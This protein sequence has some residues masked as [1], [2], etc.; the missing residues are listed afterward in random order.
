MRN[1]DYSIAT[2]FLANLFKFTEHAVEIR[3]LP[4]DTGGGQARPLFGRSLDLIEAH[5]QR[6]DDFGRAVYFGVCTR[7][8]GSPS[9]KRVDVVECPALWVDID[10][11]KVGLN[12]ADVVWQLSTMLACKP[13]AIVDSGGGLHGYW[14]L[15]EPLIVRIGEDG[16]I[17]E[18]AIIAVLKQLVGV[19]AG[20]IT[21]CD[22]ARILRLPGTHNTKPDVIAANRGEPFQVR[23]IEV[24]WSR[25]Y[26]FD[27]IVDWLD[28]QR[29]VV[30]PP[31]SL[32]TSAVRGET[33]PYLAAAARMGFKAPVNVEQ[34]LTLMTLSGDGTTSIHQ[35]QLIVSAALNQKGIAEDE[36]VSV[37]LDATRAAAGKAGDQWN[38]KR[39]EANLRSMIRSAAKKYVKPTTN[40]TSPP[41]PSAEA[42]GTGGHVVSIAAERKKRQQ[43]KTTDNDDDNDIKP[44]KAPKKG[45]DELALEFATRHSDN[46]RYV[47]SRGV[48]LHW[49][50]CKWAEDTTRYALNCVRDTLREMLLV[51]A[52][53]PN[54]AN[55]SAGTILSVEKL[56]TSDRRIAASMEIFDA[57]PW[58]LNTPDGIIDLKTGKITKSD[59]TRHCSKA[60]SVAPADILHDECPR[61]MAFLNRILKGDQSLIAYMQKLA[62]YT[63][64][65]IT[66]EQQLWFLYGR[67]RNGKGVFMSTLQSI[68]GDYA[69]TASME[70]FTETRNENHPT[71]LASLF[72]ARM[73][74]ASETSEGRAWAENRVKSLTGGDKIAARFMRQ[75][76]FTFTPTFKLWFAGNHKPALR[77][78]DPAMI[79]RFNLVPFLVEI[80]PEERDPN[81]A[82]KLQPEWPAILRWAI[83]GCLKWQKEGLKRCSAVTQESEGYIADE[84]SFSQWITACCKIGKDEVTSDHAEE[85]AAL[86][87]SWK[88]WADHTREAIGSMKKFKGRMDGKGFVHMLDNRT[89]RSIFKGIEIKRIDYTDSPRYGG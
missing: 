42:T 77:N 35:T 38:W 4:N 2:D 3:A 72:G 11:L 50:G 1:L 83:N 74:L 62:G 82:D 22:L 26:D 87:E 59:P 15:K 56:A 33:N 63:L 52:T 75:D 76:M 65:G 67:G 44:K 51:A 88:T 78:I 57:D 19:L 7:N 31:L 71:E 43:K 86:F 80:P 18:D 68:L 48:W 6:W 25:V 34:A 58:I 49:D 79:A 23:V 85:T 89:R 10:T 5:C 24:D 41:P 40:P 12:K 32:T 70:T 21:V 36:I 54:A 13:T 61:W 20:D 14:M 55:L 17:V 64:T 16:A 45:D 39:E 28:Y 84:D 73:V 30:I 53:T 29:P 37:L 27:E 69:C 9:G 81:F 60:T 46:L 8:L 47:A 66:T